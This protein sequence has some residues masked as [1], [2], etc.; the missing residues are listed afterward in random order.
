M[1]LQ[2]HRKLT[3]LITQ[4]VDLGKGYALARKHIFK[5][6]MPMTPVWLGN[7]ISKAFSGFGLAHECLFKKNGYTAIKITKTQ[8]FIQKI[9]MPGKAIN[10]LL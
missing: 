9:I 1:R 4:I 5:A 3:L 2:I 8:V 10:Y 6:F 7:K